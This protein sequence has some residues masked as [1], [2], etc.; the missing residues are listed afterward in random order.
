MDTTRADR[1]AVGGLTLDIK[2]EGDDDDEDVFVED[3]E[4]TP[5]TPT[6]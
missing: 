6:W 2:K 3:G 4:D 5:F 1:P